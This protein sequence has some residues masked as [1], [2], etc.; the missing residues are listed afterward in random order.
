MTTGSQSGAWGRLRVLDGSVGF[1][2]ATNPPMTAEPAAGDARPIPPIVTHALRVDGPVRWRSTPGPL[3]RPCRDS[4]ETCP[5]W[6]RRCARPYEAEYRTR[7][8]RH[9]SHP[10][11]RRAGH[12]FRVRRQ[13]H[14][15]AADR[16]GLPGRRA[17]GRPPVRRRRSSRGRRGTSASSSGRP[18]WAATASSASTCS[19]TSLSWPAPAWA[20]AR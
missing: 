3:S 8:G 9:A 20:A 12:R 2:M 1:T 10:R 4:G 16:E 17:R 6:L 7:H 15:A 14:G 5:R 13:G 11:L 18:G 19:A